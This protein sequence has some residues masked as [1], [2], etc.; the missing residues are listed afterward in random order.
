MK[1][2]IHD[3]PADIGRHLAERIVTGINAANQAGRPFLLG[4][5]GGRS[6]MPVYKALAKKLAD[7]KVDCS[8]VVI[9]MMDEYLHAGHTSSCVIIIIVIINRNHVK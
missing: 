3:T 4:C 7:D 6:A 1:T 5:P 8:S 2:Y 9:A